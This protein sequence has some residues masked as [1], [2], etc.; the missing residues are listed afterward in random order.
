MVDQLQHATEKRCAKRWSG[1]TPEAHQP[2][3]AGALDEPIAIVGACRFPGASI[4]PEGLW[5]MVADA[6]D[7]MSEFPPTVGGIWP[8]LFDRIPIYAI[9]R[10]PRTGSFVVA[11]LVSIRTFFDISPSECTLAMDPQHR[12]LELSW[13][14]LERAGIDPTGL[15]Q[16]HRIIRRAHRRRLR[17]VGRG[18]YR[19]TG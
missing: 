3:V 16:R 19:L 1:G 15:R 8:E 4:P 11:C 2:C 18:D 9:S 14:A 17:N 7:V 5:Q 12:M 13:E 6:R 10:T